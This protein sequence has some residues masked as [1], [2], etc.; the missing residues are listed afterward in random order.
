M[1]L[2][3]FTHS[4]CKNKDIL[5]RQII[6]NFEQHF[7]MYSFTTIKQMPNVEV[8]KDTETYVIKCTGEECDEIIDALASFKCSHF[9]DTLVPVFTKI[10][11]G[12]KIEFKTDGV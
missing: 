3:D 4:T 6:D 11:Q 2:I 12:L 10:K 9:N 7:A 5:N 8:L 1:S